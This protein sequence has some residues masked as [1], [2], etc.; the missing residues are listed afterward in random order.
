[1]CRC[2]S[3]KNTSCGATQTTC[4]ACDVFETEC[5]K[6]GAQGQEMKT[7]LWVCLQLRVQ[8]PEH[9]EEE[10]HCCQVATSLPSLPV[11]VSP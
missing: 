6:E 4:T 10:E 9:E 8:A 5:R 11:V 2:R 3:V 7:E 1:M